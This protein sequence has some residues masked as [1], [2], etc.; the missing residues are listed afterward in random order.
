MLI[1]LYFFSFN[2]FVL[3][4]NPLAIRPKLQLKTTLIF[5]LNVFF[6]DFIMFT[7]NHHYISEYSGHPFMPLPFMLMA[8]KIIILKYLE[9]WH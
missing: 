3:R 6:N 8:K 5:R 4:R 9:T 7:P 2:G 1:L